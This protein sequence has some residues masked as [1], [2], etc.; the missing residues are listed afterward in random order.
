MVD[1]DEF[2][3]FIVKQ[4]KSLDE[5][6]IEGI[7]QVFK[8]VDFNRNQLL[9]FEEF[10]IAFVNLDIL[11]RSKQFA[12]SLFSDYMVETEDGFSLD[13]SAFYHLAME[14][15][16]FKSTLLYQFLPPETEQAE[17]QEW[18][19]RADF[20]LNLWR[21]RLKDANAESEDWTKRLK[22]VEANLKVQPK[23]KMQIDGQQ[24]DSPQ[25]SP[26]LY[27]DMSLREVLIRVN[28]V[29][30]ETK[31]LY[32]EHKLKEFQSPL[33]SAFS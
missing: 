29:E 17:T 28:L 6:A 4:F 26:R 23:P 5:K 2:C 22:E 11:N 24:L 3:V 19:Q 15:N 33:V 10:Q 8:A 12:A 21:N 18:R 16:L 13:F 30:Q 1:T 27:G 32:I 14:F 9:S 7:K 25:G 20:F 31:Q